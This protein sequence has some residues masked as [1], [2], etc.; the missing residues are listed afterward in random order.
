LEAEKLDGFFSRVDY[1]FFRT[2]HD[3]RFEFRPDL[4]VHDVS[5]SEPRGILGRMRWFRRLL[6]LWSGLRSIAR[7]AKDSDPD[8][9]VAIDPFISGTIAYLLS[10]WRRIPLVVSLVSDYQLSY[11]VGSKKPVPL[12]PAWLGFAIEAWVLRRAAMV[13]VDREYYRQYAIRRGACPDRVRVAP[14]YT[15]PEYYEDGGDSDIWSTLGISDCTPLVYVGR[16]AP[17][18]Y[19][20]DLID[21]FVRI[22]RDC[23][24][25]HLVVIGG[26]PQHEEV[27][28]RADGAGVAERVHI[29]SGLSAPQIRSALR[30][31]GAVLVTHGGY[32][33]LEACLAGA[34]VVAYDFEWHPEIIIHGETGLLAPYRNWQAMADGAL[35][36]LSNR[37]K[38]ATLGGKARAMAR[39]SYHRSLNIARQREHYA[40]LLSDCQA[41]SCD[42]FS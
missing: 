32:A 34:A 23:P 5:G 17:E 36:L 2:E 33:L 24:E 28:K 16:L 37:S 35:E 8:V 10:R 15:A 30:R 13:L 41:H 12:L 14:V 6:L 31:S 1:V 25:R 3:A 27:M 22:A 19:S 20:L 29:L 11:K 42:E 39:K 26:G 21:C 4:Y 40:E 18:K 9:V 7:L 38:A